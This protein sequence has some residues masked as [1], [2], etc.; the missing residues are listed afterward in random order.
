MVLT[1]PE[2]RCV[3]SEGRC[4]GLD[5]N[6]CPIFK[7]KYSPADYDWVCSFCSPG[8]WDEWDSGGRRELPIEGVYSS[9]TC[10]RCLNER[11]LLFPVPKRVDHP[12]P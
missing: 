5:C 6:T 4:P 8:Q 11:L 10:C 2:A 12:A 1:S 3:I 7:A 9:G